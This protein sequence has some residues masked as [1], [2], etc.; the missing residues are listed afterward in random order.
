MSITNYYK[1]LLL[2]FML[3]LSLSKV[4]GQFPSIERVRLNPLQGNNDLT[5]FCYNELRQDTL[6]RLWMKTCGVAQQLYAIRVFQFDG[7]ERWPIA[8]ARGAWQNNN[9]VVLEGFST[10]GQWLGY[11][12][13]EK[14][15]RSTLFSYEVQTDTV[16]YTSIP[17]GRCIG[18]EE[19][20]TGKFWVLT[21]HEEDYKIYHW[22]GLRLQLR[23]TF[24]SNFPLDYDYRKRQTVSFTY[25]DHSFWLLYGG[26]P[27]LGYN[28]LTNTTHEIERSVFAALAKRRIVKETQA[29]KSIN[30]I[31]RD[32]IIYLT[33]HNAGTPF[34]KINNRRLEEGPQVFLEV[35]DGSQA[36]YLWKDEQGHLLFA[37]R[38]KDT[39]SFGA[40]LLDTDNRIFDYSPMLKD[41]PNIRSIHGKNFKQSAFVGTSSGAFFVQARQKSSIQTYPQLTRLRHMVAQDN[42]EVLLRSKRDLYVLK[43]DTLLKLPPSHCLLQKA[44][45]K[46]RKDIIKGP[47]GK[48]WL[49]TR[50]RLIQPN[51]LEN[52]TCTIYDLDQELTTATFISED[53]LAMLE[54]ETNRLFLYD[55]ATQQEL[56]FKNNQTHIFPSRVHEMWITDKK[57]L[58][59]GCNDGLYK[60]DL[61]SGAVRQYGNT[62]DFEDYRILSLLEDRQGRLW[63]GTASRG[64]HIFNPER[65]QVERIINEPGGLSNNVVVG[66]LEDEEGDIWAATYNGLNLLQPDGTVVAI[67]EEKDGLTNNEFNRYAHCKANDGR[68]YFGT[69]E[70]LNIIEPPQ[71][72]Q[73]LKDT[74]SS[75]IYTTSIS[76]FDSKVDQTIQLRNFLPSEK[77]LVLPADKRFL[78][79]N[80]GLSNY[81]Q[82]TNNRYAYRLEGKQNEWTLLGNEHLIRL[83][84][85]P[86]GKYDLLVKGID[87]NGNWTSNTIRIPIYAKEFFY[88]QWW[89]YVLCAMPFLIFAFLWIRRLRSEKYR[90]EQEV[91]KRTLEIRK[92]KE[93]IQE[94]AEELQQLDKMKSRFFANISHDLRTPITLI[95]GPAELL[96]E[97]EYI[98][99]KSVFHQ[100]IL[101]IGQNSKKLLRLVEEFLDLARLESKTIRLHE[102]SIPLVEFIQAIF[103]SYALAAQRKQLH[104]EF[105]PALPAH[106]HLTVDPKRLEKIINNLLSNALKFTAPGD[107]IRIR[108]SQVQEQVILEVQDTGRGIPPE[109]LP[110][111]FKRFFQSQ[112]EKLIQTSGSGIGLSLCQDFAQLMG[113]QLTVNS[114]FGEGSTFRLSLPNKERQSSKPLQPIS[115]NNP[116]IHTPPSTSKPLNPQ[117]PNPPNPS[118]VTQ[119]PSPKPLNPSTPK[120]LNTQTPNPSPVTQNPQSPKFVTRHPKPVTPNPQTPQLLNPST[121]QLMI[122]EDNPEVQSFLQL[123]LQDDY[124]VLPFDDGQYA[125]EFLQSH[126]GKDRPVDLILSDINMPRLDG[127]G[128]I[129]AV[130]QEEQWQQIPMVMLT[131]HLQ[132]RSKLKALRMGVDDYLTKPFSPIE[133]KVRLKNIYDNYQ[134]RL[135]AQKEYFAVNPDFEPT[136]SADQS[137]IEELEEYALRAVD[138]QINLTTSYLAE[139]M[140][141]G[142][143]QM[144]R[145]VKLLT[146]LTIGKYI[147]EIKL[148]K[149]RHLLEQKAFPTVAETGYACGFN[150]PSYFAKLFHRHFGKPPT[151]YYN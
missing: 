53:T 10:T 32:S 114:T 87:H 22:D 79:I 42:Q 74:E 57:I 118:L 91:D 108:I 5:T 52:D 138:G 59:A 97:E 65:E 121:P 101:T 55:L 50:N 104:F 135:V 46:G 16:R 58:W 131:A 142:E 107:S 89:F 145:K 2:P 15:Q 100:A 148:Q 64:I 49:T 44:V 98:K 95:A 39:K 93:L 33:N 40:Y 19:Y 48:A 151:S 62:P 126:K 137:W 136:I 14:A 88:K 29:T 115:K 99:K 120:P 83:A 92:D 35:P 90:L 11:F 109:D 36:E 28:T 26:L 41:L 141:L 81:G 8:I 122:A 9:T 47:K 72:K 3:L 76:Y 21:W 127:Y 140:A 113:G 68:L 69:V 18:I 66:I 116:A 82:N 60:I 124:H 1:A 17:E 67:F 117:T 30:L 31:G 110:H 70:G 129:E 86:A 132:E 128:L 106:F 102:V 147:Q 43:S 4:M 38:H 24:P 27:V 123:L 37:Y 12:Y 71:L 80:V 112:N 85:L 139:K 146:G 34:F 144:A 51:S 94:L 6:G 84:S 150:S 125:L 96:A 133:L 20:Q 134:K 56:P 103:D 78:S 105:T 23:Y 143:R 77:A 13:E 119:N 149:A 63:L 45:S 7:Y 111:I 54:Y 75:Q 25:T 130:K 61:T 73:V